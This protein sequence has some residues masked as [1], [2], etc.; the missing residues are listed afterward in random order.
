MRVLFAAFVAL[1]AGAITASACDRGMI[2]PTPV[3]PVPASVWRDNA[4][5][6]FLLGRD[7]DS[8]DVRM[9]LISRFRT[10]PHF[11][12]LRGGA[13]NWPA[14]YRAMQAL[15]QDIQRDASI[16]NRLNQL[17]EAIDRAALGGAPLD[18]QEW[19]AEL[20]GI[21][22]R[23]DQLIGQASGVGPRLMQYADVLS[24]TSGHYARAGFRPID[25]ADIGPDPAAVSVALD[26]LRGRWHALQADLEFA[27]K[28]LPAGP[29]LDEATI[30]GL[31]LAGASFR[32]VTA[33]AQGL[34]ANF[35]P[36]QEFE[37][38]ASGSYLYDA[39]KVAESG[40][41]QLRN[42]FQPE[43]ALTLQGDKTVVAQP[44]GDRDRSCW[45]LHRQENGYWT[46][47][48]AASG[49][50]VLEVANLPAAA[51][52]P[53]PEGRGW[54]AA[55]VAALALLSVAFRRVFPPFQRH[56]GRGAVA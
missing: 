21:T 49:G 32:L 3:E 11:A 25:F 39:C 12:E 23:L 24:A 37:A 15:T 19:T 31:A 2:A 35:L 50:K 17:C 48:N 5:F 54:G 34:G 28:S 43:N 1:L 9:E 16:S 51:F 26:S 33:E 22:L 38:L 46:I 52:S 45:T 18:E 27:R 4:R 56:A 53:T 10:I 14:D 7:Y 29:A 6:S 42:R 44:E 55:H 30:E 36:A 8:R 20:R 40:S 47:A 41:I 13:A